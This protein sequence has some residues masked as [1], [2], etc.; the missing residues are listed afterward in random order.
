MF[1][2]EV[3]EGVGMSDEFAAG[4]DLLDQVNGKICIGNLNPFDNLANHGINFIVDDK[5]SVVEGDTEIE[6]TCTVDE[7]GATLGC[8]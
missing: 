8:Q 2:A 1:V 4:A 3:C 6:H 7:V 5:L